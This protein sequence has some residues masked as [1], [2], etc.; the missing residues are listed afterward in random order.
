MDALKT[1]NIRSI[2]LT[3]ILVTFIGSGDAADGEIAKEI[4]YSTLFG[5]LLDPVADKAFFLVPGGKLILFITRRRDLLSK[6]SLTIGVTLFLAEVILVLIG[7][8]G[9][10]ISKY[11][12]VKLGSNFFG[13]LKF[14]DECFWLLGVSI[15]IAIRQ[16]YKLDIYYSIHIFTIIVLSGAIVFASLSI[17]EHIRSLKTQPTSGGLN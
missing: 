8:A 10:I 4:G 2:V 16:I 6:I 3:I 15:M 9:Y 14:P 5:K 12:E 17:F 11:R 7:A 13:K 1:G